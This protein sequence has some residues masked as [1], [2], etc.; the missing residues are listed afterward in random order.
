MVLPFL[1]IAVGIF[2]MIK[3]R[4]A[5]SGVSAKFYAGTLLVSLPLGVIAYIASGIIAARIRNEGHFYSV[6]FGGYTAS[7]DAALLASTV[8]WI[9]LVCVCL[10]AIF[11]PRN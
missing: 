2:L 6:P 10:A 7:N 4:T 8:V 1:L 3:A 9:A 5:A 11:R